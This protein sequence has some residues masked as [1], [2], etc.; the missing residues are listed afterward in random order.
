[1]LQSD[2][3]WSADGRHGAIIAIYIYKSESYVI[4]VSKFRDDAR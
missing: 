2:L 3:G 4:V 1:M